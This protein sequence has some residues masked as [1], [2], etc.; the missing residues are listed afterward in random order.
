MLLA[1]AA[2][3]LDDLHA[4]LA[5]VPLNNNYTI[6]PPEFSLLFFIIT[7]CL[8]LLSYFTSTSSSAK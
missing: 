5:V 2:M 1:T 4:L 8:T 6:G 3:F 7:C